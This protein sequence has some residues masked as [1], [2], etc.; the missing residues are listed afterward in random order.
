MM[1]NQFLKFSKGKTRSQAMMMG[2]HLQNKQERM[3]QKRERKRE[4]KEEQISNDSVY[5]KIAKQLRSY[6]S[7][8]DI[9]SIAN[10]Y[11][12]L[13][14]L[15]TRPI[16]ID[17]IPFVIPWASVSAKHEAK[18]AKVARRREVTQAEQIWYHR[19]KIGNGSFGSIFAGINT[20]DGRKV[21]VKR[22]DKSRPSC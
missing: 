11:P 21:A 4:S 9:D 17:N 3:N 6:A 14:D 18:L 13:Q 22:I 8:I 1:D 2:N 7:D 15:L 20:K 16:E 5:C 12:S 10:D 19:D